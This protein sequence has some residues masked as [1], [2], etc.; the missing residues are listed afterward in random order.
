[1][2]QYLTCEEFRNL[3]G[4]EISENFLI[5]A[6]NQIDILTFQRIKKIGFENLTSL[7]KELIQNVCAQQAL[8]LQDYGEMLNSPLSSYSIAGVSMSWNS[9]NLVNISGITMQNESYQH[10]LQT[11]LCNLA[12]R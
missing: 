3:T 8:F 5:Q 1:M 2:S 4:K 12:L 7:Q 10:L 6:S 11:N 9:Q